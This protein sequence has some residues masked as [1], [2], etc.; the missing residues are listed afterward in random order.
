MVKIGEGLKE[1]KKKV[2]KL[3]SGRIFDEEPIGSTFHKLPVDI[4]NSTYKQEDG[5]VKPLKPLRIKKPLKKQSDTLNKFPIDIDFE[6]IAKN[7]DFQRFVI[8]LFKREFPNQFKNVSTRTTGAKMKEQFD[9]AVKKIN[10]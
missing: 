6:A 8:G 9:K 10:N 1:N 7:S 3:P 4:T 2:N 5:F